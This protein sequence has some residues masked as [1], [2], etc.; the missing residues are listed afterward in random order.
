ML[1][2]TV[3]SVSRY[4][5]CPRGRHVAKRSDDRPKEMPK[6]RFTGD[7]RLIDKARHKKVAKYKL[8][9]GYKKALRD[10]GAGGRTEQY[11]L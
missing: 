2:R 1:A 7:R 3:R 11:R 10:D 4:P 9:A 5:R 6:P 8:Y